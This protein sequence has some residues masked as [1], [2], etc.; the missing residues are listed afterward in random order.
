MSGYRVYL[1]NDTEGHVVMTITRTLAPGVE[2]PA[3]VLHLDADECLDLE[4][5]LAAVRKKGA[6]RPLRVHAVA[7]GFW[8]FSC[9]DHPADGLGLWHDQ[10][11][12]SD[13]AIHHLRTHHQETK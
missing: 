13:A 12:A 11:S 1:A 9:T 2:L 10:P 4:R 5:R 8:S 7:D 6:S 3:A